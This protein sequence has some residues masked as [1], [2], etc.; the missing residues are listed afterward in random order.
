[1]QFRAT[2]VIT[3]VNRRWPELGIQP[4]GQIEARR[5]ASRGQAISR[6]PT[7]AVRHD[8]RD[9]AVALER[10]CHVRK[11]PRLRH[12]PPHQAPR[13]E[14]DISADARLHRRARRDGARIV[15]IASRSRDLPRARAQADA[16]QSARA[17]ALRVDDVLPAFAKC[18]SAI[19]S[20]ASSPD[21]QRPLLHARERF[22]HGQ[23]HASGGQHF[24]RWVDFLDPS[25]KHGRRLP[26]VLAGRARFEAAAGISDARERQDQ[27]QEWQQAAH[28]RVGF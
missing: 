14:H 20:A 8:A 12:R 23:S 22:D 21:L 18:E 2:S 1:M 26:V 4:F 24:G 5:I 7:V 28:F 25:E 9:L 13:C 15:Q 6:E 19:R 16:Q 10:D 3:Q 27:D 11:R 17:G